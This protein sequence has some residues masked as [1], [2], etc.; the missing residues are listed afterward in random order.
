MEFL[1]K[2]SKS[3]MPGIEAVDLVFRNEER[4]LIGL[5]N[6]ELTHLSKEQLV[7][8][9]KKRV[10][11]TQPSWFQKE[12]VYQFKQLNRQLKLEDEDRLTTLVLPFESNIDGYSDLLIIHFH[13]RIGIKSFDKAFKNLT[14][15]EKAL[16]SSLL[17]NSLKNDFITVTE[18]KEAFEQIKV[19]YAKV[20][21]ENNSLKTRLNGTEEMY[22]QAIVR[23]TYSITSALEKD[24]NCKISIDDASIRKIIVHHLN[25]KQLES[26]ILN[27]FYIAYNLSMGSSEI[28]IHESHVEIDKSDENEISRS[29]Y[30]GDKIIALL[31]RYENAAEKAFENGLPVNGKNVATHLSPAVSP[32]AI[33]DALK[34]HNK[35]IGLLLEQFPSKWKLIR[36]NLKPLQVHQ[37]KIEFRYRATG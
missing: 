19:H 15:D 20:Q 6:N 10:E 34:K 35:K 26:L 24:Y 37:E 17:Y 21:E 31:D 12:E 2:K 5:F 3:L 23:L 32:P 36:K 9:Q 28:T 13:Q 22:K 1:L 16:I 27:A 11:I 14:T 33:T 4:E 18:D 29:K 7:S 8:F 30:S 25:Y